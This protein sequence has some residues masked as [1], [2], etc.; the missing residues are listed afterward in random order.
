M[1]NV[2]TSTVI[3]IELYRNETTVFLESN[4]GTL[5]HINC[6]EKAHHWIRRI[7][8]TTDYEYDGLW[9]RRIVNTADC[10]YG[11]LWIRRIVNTTDCEYDG[12]WKRRIVNTT[13]YEY[14]EM[15]PQFFR[16]Q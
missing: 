2:V 7:M 13:D 1:G 5:K 10:E 4:N 6:L 8:N 11:G 3:I 16:R 14:T 12:L 9:V 15:K